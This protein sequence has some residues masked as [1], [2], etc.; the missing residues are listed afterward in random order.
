MDSVSSKSVF[1]FIEFY[2][3]GLH[4]WCGISYATSKKIH[5]R[6][7]HKFKQIYD[8]EIQNLGIFHSFRCFSCKSERA[9]C[10]QIPISRHL[11]RF[12]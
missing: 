5:R 3:F 9:S 10:D 12:A 8:L 11:I 2:E 7:T 1:N 6:R 4:Q